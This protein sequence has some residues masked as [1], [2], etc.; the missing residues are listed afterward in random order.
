MRLFKNDVFILDNGGGAML[1]CN[2]DCRL[3]FDGGGPIG[4]S[5]GMGLEN[6]EEIKMIIV[7]VGGG[8]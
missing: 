4:K 7:G 8:A 2:N 1:V 3:Y 5:N 6:N